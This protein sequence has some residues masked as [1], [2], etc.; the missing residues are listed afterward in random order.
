MNAKAMDL[1]DPVLLGHLQKG[2]SS[3]GEVKVACEE[4]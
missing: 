2:L 1:K 3:P 4:T